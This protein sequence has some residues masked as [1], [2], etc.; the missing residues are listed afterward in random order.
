MAKKLYLW[1]KFYCREGLAVRIASLV[2]IERICDTDGSGR[3]ISRIILIIN[4]KDYSSDNPGMTAASSLAAA[5]A[6]QAAG[7]DPKKVKNIIFD[8]GGV[9]ID[10]RREDAVAALQALGLENADSLLGLYRQEE[11]FLGIETG[12][13]TVGEFFET[14]RKQCPGATDVEITEA[15]NRFLV[16]IPKERLQRLRQLREKGYR[17]Y[18]LSNTNPIMYNSWIA[19]HFRQEGYTI[20]DYF[21][22]IV[23]SF[24]E[25]TCK[26]DPEI[27]STVVRRYR[28]DP[29]ETL[30]LDDSQA[31]CES[32]RS[33]GLSAL[34]IG[35]DPEAGMI[36]ITE[37]L[38][39][40]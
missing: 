32:A 24:Q 12:R 34:Q 28:L 2:S 19:E 26:P 22:G 33:I 40:R 23:C 39:L 15:F 3:R 4:M 29:A 10:L 20:N 31:N 35:K 5:A 14:I 38:C 7:I 1:S 18:V 37:P 6:Y 17:L 30:M 9:V 16:G 11:P 36:A 25:L 27:F 13:I 21:D 8:L